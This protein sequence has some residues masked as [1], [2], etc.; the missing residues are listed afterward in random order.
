MDKNLE[1]KT[2]ETEST[3]SNFLSVSTNL[4]VGT[5]RYIDIKKRGMKFVENHQILEGQGYQKHV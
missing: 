4:P 2:E 1:K 5:G 3:K